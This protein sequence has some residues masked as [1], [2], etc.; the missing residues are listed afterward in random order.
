[1][2]GRRGGRDTKKTEKETPNQNDEN[3]VLDGFPL[4]RHFRF[5]RHSAASI[6]RK[7]SK[8][9]SFKSW[10]P[11]S[12]AASARNGYSVTIEHTIEPSICC[13]L[14]T[15]ILYTN[16]NPKKSNIN[17]DFL[18]LYAQRSSM[19]AYFDA[20]CLFSCGCPLSLFKCWSHVLYAY[21]VCTVLT[22]HREKRHF[23]SIAN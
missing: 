22:V 8:M 3:D 13:R 17:S 5:V 18:F 15:A 23:I 14:S 6:E 16:G 21:A 7:I 2:G 10:S 12:A 19:T 11:S 20:R 4:P 9:C 1:M